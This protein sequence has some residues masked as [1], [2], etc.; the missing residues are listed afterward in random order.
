MP[1]PVAKAIRAEDTSETIRDASVEDIDALLDIENRC[2]DTDKLTRRSF[3]WMLTKGKSTMLVAEHGGAI[4]GYILVLYHQGTSLARLYSIAV[5]PEY[6]KSGIALRLATAAEAGAQERNCVYMRLEVRRDNASAI[7]FYERLGYK[8]IGIWP[9]YY[10]DHMEA[11]RYQKRIQFTQP[12]SRIQVPFYAQTTDFTCGPSALMMAMKAHDPEFALSPETELQ[13]WREATTIFMT[14]GHGG[15]G[16]HGLALAA[17]RRGFAAEVYLSDAGPLFLDGVRRESKKKVMRLVHEQ[18][19]R[20]AAK[21][22]LPIRVAPLSVDDISAKMAVGGVPLVLISSYLL[23]QKKMPHWVVLT[24]VDSRFIYAH[25]PAVEEDMHK[26]ALDCIN[27]PIA[28]GRF[29]RM[30]QYGRS[31]LKAVVMIYPRREK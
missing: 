31:Q 11:L 1:S 2:F 20:E 22:G 12:H 16:P 7:R 3:H 23:T 25:D 19:V 18:F 5:L 15:C 17:W 30:A 26:S 13:I 4:I 14:S 24:A 10:E 27:V 28:K 21:S 9:D 6:R 8:A 29:G